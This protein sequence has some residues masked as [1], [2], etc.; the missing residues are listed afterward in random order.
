MMT[1]SFLE[2][3]SMANYKLEIRHRHVTSQCPGKNV[4]SEALGPALKETANGDPNI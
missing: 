2:A 4:M 3:V 1:E